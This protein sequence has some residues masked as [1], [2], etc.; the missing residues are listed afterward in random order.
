MDIKDD[1]L[2]WFTSFF[3]KNLVEVVL[4]RIIN[5]QMNIISKLLENLKEEK[6]ILHLKT[7]FG[8]HI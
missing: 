4:C 7:I 3:I 6:F 2:Q 1:Q 5:L 8:V